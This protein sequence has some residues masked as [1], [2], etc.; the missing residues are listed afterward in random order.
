MRY[1]GVHTFTIP[2]VLRSPPGYRFGDSLPWILVNFSFE[3]K[4]K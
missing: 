4:A 1:G 2:S 3:L